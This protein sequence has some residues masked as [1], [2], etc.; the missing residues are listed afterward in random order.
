MRVREILESSSPATRSAFKKLLPK[1]TFPSHTTLPYPSALLSILP[2]ESSY[3]LLG[4]LAEHLLQKPS[5]EITLDALQDLILAV[6]GDVTEKELEKVETSITTEPFLEALQN[7][8]RLLERAQASPI[9]YNKVLEYQGVQGHP[10]GINSTQVFEVKLTGRFEKNWDSFL[11]QVF[12]Y[13]SL[14]PSIETVYIVLPLQQMLWKHKV[15]GWEGRTEF[16]NLLVSTAKRFTENSFSNLTGALLCE[17]YNIGCHIPKLKSL[18]S[19]VKSIPD[20][21]KPF[22]IFLGNPQSSK[23]SFQDKELAEASQ[24]VSATGA[25]LYVHTPYIINLSTKVEGDAWNVELLKKNIQ[26]SN[27]VGCKG[28]V[29]HVGKSTKQ[30]PTLAT[31]IMRQNI[32]S[33]LEYTTPECP[34][35]L[36]TPAGQG[37]ELL[38]DKKRFLDF[39]ASFQDERLRVCVDTCHVFA[40]GHKPLEYISMFDTQPGL[41]KLI[42]YNDSATPCGSCKDRHAFVGTGHI[43]LDGM[44]KIAQLCSGKGIPM[45]VE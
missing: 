25:Q 42:H 18:T 34:L 28:V 8:R 9:E 30:D 14:C 44:T 40:C 32:Q 29:V 23:V 45:V 5:I 3:S 7:T 13:A 24:L 38:T 31:E 33:V 17:T 6:Y 41:L 22:Q 36:E 12:S 11:L 35:L 21:K 19:T 4:I 15:T 39:A 27:T 16:R 1:T 43:G 2:K 10:D 37:T 26:Y 20:L